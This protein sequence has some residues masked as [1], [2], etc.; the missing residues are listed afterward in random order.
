MSDVIYQQFKKETEA[1]QPTLPVSTPAPAPAPTP[2]SSEEEA[3]SKN[4]P[5]G[6]AFA[7]LNGGGGGMSPVQQDVYKLIQAKLLNPGTSTTEDYRRMVMQLNAGKVPGMTGSLMPPPPPTGGAVLS[8][9]SPTITAPF[10]HMFTQDQINQY[11]IKEPMMVYQP[12][13]GK[14]GAPDFKE[15]SLEWW[16]PNAK[17]VF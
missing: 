15:G 3:A 6:Q 7:N 12:T 2:S 10:R 13:A 8:G 9:S 4:D 14:D 1:R 11:A 16:K 5:L 17:P